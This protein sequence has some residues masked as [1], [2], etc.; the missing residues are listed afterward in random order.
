MKSADGVIYFISDGTNIKI[1]QTVRLAVRFAELQTGNPH[2]LTVVKT[3]RFKRDELNLYEKVLHNLFSQYRLRKNSEWFFYHPEIRD[4]IKTLTNRN[5]RF[6]Y[7][8]FGN[9][10]TDDVR[11]EWMKYGNKIIANRCYVSKKED[12]ANG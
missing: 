9:P 12:D 8:H 5:I 1:G 7:S 10:K 6:M 4:Y 11:N 2:E 3:M